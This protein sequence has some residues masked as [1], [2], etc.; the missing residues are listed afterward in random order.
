MVKDL[1]YGHGSEDS[2][3]TLW[4]PMNVMKNNP[5][6]VVTKISHID[7]APFL[8]LNHIWTCKMLWMMYG[9]KIDA[10]SYMVI[11]FLHINGFINT[12]IPLILKQ[13]L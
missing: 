5:I 11:I 6:I 2:N 13:I 8:L 4:H 9:H 10:Y 7:M 1:P 12:E 3:L